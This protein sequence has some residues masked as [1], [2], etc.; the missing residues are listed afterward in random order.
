MELLAEGN[1]LEKVSTK[2]LKLKDEVG[3]MTNL[4]NSVADQ[5]NLLALNAAIE[6]ARAGESGKGFSVV[7][8][9]IRKL[10]EKSKQSSEN[11]NK[12]INVI[13]SNADIIVNDSVTMDNELINQVKIIDNSITSFKKIIVAVDE[14]IPKIDTVKNSVEKIEVDKNT[15][16]SRIDGL[17]SISEEI[18]A[19]SEEMSASTEEVA[20]SSQTLNKM[21]NE[22]MNEVNKFKV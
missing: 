2:Y 12:L 18:S 14:V 13:S 19:S 17:S 8:D 1:L 11:I 7:A 9:E 15:I 4:I 16:L 10:A 22:M 3:S 6:A 20:L 21:T 5:T